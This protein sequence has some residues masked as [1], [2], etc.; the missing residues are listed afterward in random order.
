[1]SHFF[2]FFGLPNFFGGASGEPAAS[3]EAIASHAFARSGCLMASATS[4][5][6]KL[7]TLSRCP[8]AKSSMARASD[9]ET[10]TPQL[11]PS[12][13]LGSRL[14]IAVKSVAGRSSVCT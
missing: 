7:A 1:M 6:K 3:S 10:R 11:R 8:W 4:T 12:V 2:G 14:P 13:G 5:R 9:G